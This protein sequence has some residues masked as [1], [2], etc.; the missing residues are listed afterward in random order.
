MVAQSESD[1]VGVFGPVR[2]GGVL[3]NNPV[4]N[5]AGTYGLGVECG[6]Y[7]DLSALGAFVTKSIS[8]DP[9]SG[10]SGNNVIPTAQ[11]GMLN[12]VGL[13]NP[14]IRAWIEKDYPR[15]AESEAKV[16]VSIWGTTIDRTSAV[17]AAVER[18]TDAV[19]IEVNLSCPNSG[20]PH[21]LVSHDPGLIARQVGAIVQRVDPLPVWAKL[22]ASA[23]DMVAC[24]AAATKA[25]A[26][27]IT[28][29][30][31]I[32]AMAVDVNRKRPVLSG[33]F[34]GLSGPPLH[35]IAL[36]AVYQVH[37]W[38]PEIPIIGVGGIIDGE[39]ALE[40]LQVGAS[41][42]QVGTASFADPRAPHRV[43]GQLATAL[44]ARDLSYPSV[45]GVAVDRMPPHEYGV[46]QAAPSSPEPP[47]V[48]RSRIDAP[49]WS[50]RGIQPRERRS[51]L[52]GEW[53]PRGFGRPPTR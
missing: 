23:P 3:L 2:V 19:A 18:E 46:R 39:T 53:L 38:R 7:G 1:K 21:L 52:R 51:S 11:V 6:A 44:R 29:V 13:K 27:G 32:S 9:W 16:V 8:Y 5:A 33:I 14:G 15:L 12:S 47:A 10:N 28:L 4:L 26:S 24:A 45:V 36:R 48:R 35:P 22:A 49:A 37:M 42:L 30:N 25:G 50:P 20:N 17:A 40:M 34:G 41:A 43:L 31:T